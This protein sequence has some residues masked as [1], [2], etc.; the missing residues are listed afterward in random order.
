MDAL[1]NLREAKE[2]LKQAK[3]SAREPAQDYER[4]VAKAEVGVAKVKYEIEK[5]KVEAL[6]AANTAVG[7]A[8]TAAREDELLGAIKDKETA[9]QDWNNAKVE[10]SKLA[11]ALR[12]PA[13]PTQ[14]GLFLWK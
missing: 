1:D 11:G 7:A 12:L 10:H 5:A 2:A 8:W 3:E 4:R 13:L 14:A 6:L 9:L